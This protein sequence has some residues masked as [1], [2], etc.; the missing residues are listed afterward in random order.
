M[1]SSFFFYDLETSGLRPASARIMQFAGQRTDMDLNPIGEPINVLIKLTPDVLPEPDAVFLTGI[2]PQQT[3]EFGITE[4]AFLELFYEEIATPGTIFVGFNNVRFD[5]EFI[6]YLNYRNFYDPYVW[7]WKDNRSRWDILDLVRMTRALRPDGIEWPFKDSK[8]VNRLEMLTKANKLDH[9]SAHDALSDVTATIA[10]AK[11]IKTKQPKLFSYLFN[12]R[13][14]AAVAELIKGDQPFVYTSSHFPSE[15]LHTTIVAPLAPRLGNDSSLVYNLRVDPSPFLAMS[16][17]ELI[18]AWQFNE[19]PEAVRLPVK[20]LKY[21]RVP[22]VAPLSVIDEETTKRLNLDMDQIW[23]NYEV[24][25]SSKEEFSNKLAEAL[26]SMDSTRNAKQAE[27]QLEADHDL[28][29]SF[30]ENVDAKLFP[31]IHASSPDKLDD[32]RLK[33]HDKRLKK[34]LPLYKARNFPDELNASEQKAWNDFIGSRLSSENVDRYLKRVNELSLQA[35]MS[36]QKQIIE[37]LLD[38]L[39]LVS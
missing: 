17:S 27:L 9:S 8:P 26:E 1:S 3:L 33:L 38:Y 32:F 34:L 10:V 11:L 35:K 19:D 15:Y 16:P 22:A 23:K 30:I 36:K 13:S 20:T 31:L 28:Y 5:D 21:N 2:T 12:L 37:S 29:G 6:R 14:K 25:Q 7:S 39:N 4:A 24:L 18:D